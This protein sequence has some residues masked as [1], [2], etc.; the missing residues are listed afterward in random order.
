MSLFFL[1]SLFLSF[2]LDAQ[3]VT[4]NDVHVRPG[5]ECDFC[6]QSSNPAPGSAALIMPDQS[7]LCESCHTGADEPHHP[8]KFSPLDFN[9]KTMN[10]NII[11]E[12][13]RFYISGDKGKLPIFGK[14][15]ETAVVE[16]TTC[17]DPHGRSGIRKLLRIDDANSGLCLTCHLY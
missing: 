14:D 15:R 6:H 1:L 17:H 2:T 7:L 10:Q 13:K 4:F 8:I 16:C 9:P 11:M 3:A 5:S 12:K